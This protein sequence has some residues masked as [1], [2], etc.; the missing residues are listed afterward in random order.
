MEKQ[1]KVIT[2]GEYESAFWQSDGTG[3]N[4][5]ERQ[6][7]TYHPYK[8]DLLAEADLA[9][10]PETAA[11]ISAAEHAV[12]QLNERTQYLT[13]TEPLAR[14]MLRSEAMASSR[15][16]GLAVS[17]QKLLEF[18]ALD[19]M[20]VE[21][22][23]DST[24]ASVL[25]NIAAMQQGINDASTL[26]HIS[27]TD[28]CHIHKL[29]LANTPD[30]HLGGMLRAEQNWIGGNRMNPIGARYVPPRPTYVRNL[31]DDLIAFCNNSI[32]SPLATAAI[33]H[34]Q[35]ETIHPFADGNGRTGR[36]LVHTILKHS[37]LVK[38]VVP[39]ISLLL[40]TDKQRYIDNLAAF[41][42]EGFNEQ[43]RVDNLNNWVEYFAHITK[44]ACERA[45]EFEGTITALQTEWL[46]AASPRA[47][48]TAES[49]I[50]ELP[51]C[52]VFS[53]SMAAKTLN[54]SLPATRN[55]IKS[56]VEQG[57]LVQN[58]KNKKSSIYVAQ[59]IMDAFTSYERALASID[60]DTSVS[61]PTRPVPQRV[62]R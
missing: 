29:L 2:M 45:F 13:N 53:V 54:R 37:G 51:K 27:L 60:G 22:Y 57:I 7:G 21:H 5:R 39:P 14:L 11:A 17:A 49:L 6:S 48:S 52:P 38:S 3:M 4:R 32:Y 9:L 31:M 35:F 16:E 26:E 15:I 33:V 18:E 46:R 43:D 58:S 25:G 59:G 50:K 34:A 20:G 47:G 19:E 1:R 23:L 10:Y 24:E 61:K 40:A 62:K 42:T 28:I 12:S 30:A 55:A 41:R 36:T 8:P 56:L 44:L